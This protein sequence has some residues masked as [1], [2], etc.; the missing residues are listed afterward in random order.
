MTDIQ[1]QFYSGQ[2][3]N[4]F[5]AITDDHIRAIYYKMVGLGLIGATTVTKSEPTIKPAA[6]AD[7]DVWEYDQVTMMDSAYRSVAS[8]YGDIPATHINGLSAIIASIRRGEVPGLTTTDAEEKLAQK[9]LKRI[10]ENTELL[11]ENQ[12]IKAEVERLRAE[13]ATQKTDNGGL[14]SDLMA[15][16]GERYAAIARAEK[17]EEE[18]ERQVMTHQTD[19]EAMS[20]DRQAARSAHA[21]AMALLKYIDDNYD[22]ADY[23]RRIDSDIKTYLAKHQNKDASK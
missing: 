7:D 1:L 9:L 20:A 5:G 15:A 12:S 3:G 23:S 17:A 14:L 19:M 4:V 2:N 18:L 8:I 13:L 10:A 6:P 22:M 21:E 11:F 16:R